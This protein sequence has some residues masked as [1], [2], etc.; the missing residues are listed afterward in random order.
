MCTLLTFH[1]NHLIFEDCQGVRTAG[2]M[3]LSTVAPKAHQRWEAKAEGRSIHFEEAGGLDALVHCTKWAFSRVQPPEWLP[4][5]ITAL[6][7]ESD[8]VDQLHLAHL[9]SSNPQDVEL[10]SRHELF[11]ELLVSI[12]VDHIAAG[13]LELRSLAF[14]LY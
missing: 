8:P 9:D 7:V 3:V 1:P 10:Y 5:A 13:S 4:S 14:R 11:E 6:K 2:A 12:E